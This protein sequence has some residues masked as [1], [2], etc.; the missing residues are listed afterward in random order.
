MLKDDLFNIMATENVSIT[1]LAARLNVSSAM[2]SYVINGQRQPG[3]KMLRGLWKNYR[4]ICKKYL[5]SK[6]GEK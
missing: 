6:E 1:Q 5:E 4:T 3:I 2:L